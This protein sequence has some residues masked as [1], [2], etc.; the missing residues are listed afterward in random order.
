MGA[1]QATELDAADIISQLMTTRNQVTHQLHSQKQ[2]S[3]DRELKTTAN[4]EILKGWAE[5][6]N[7]HCLKVG[8][9][10]KPMNTG[11]SSPS[12]K[13]RIDTMLVM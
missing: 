4:E 7:N 1:P 6:L 10:A 5:I 8:F 3:F 2:D 9:R 11:D 13:L 12:T